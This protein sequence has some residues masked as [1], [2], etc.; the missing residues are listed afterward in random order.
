LVALGRYMSLWLRFPQLRGRLFFVAQGAE[1]RVEHGARIEFGRNVR[2][3]R[4]FTAHFAG[5]VV[6]G[7]SV[8]FNRGC[9]VV[10][11]ERLVI[12]AHCL[13]GEGVSIHDENHRIGRDA[14]PIARRGFSTAP[15]H[16]GRNVWV[17]A[18]VT[19]LQGVSIGDNAV[20]GA[21]A[22]VTHDIP[23]N[24]LALGIPAHVARTI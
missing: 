8:F 17:G 18:R 1:I 10:V 15:I 2:F 14:T 4:D 24:A 11:H 9:H 5:H 7:D 21:G 13:F 19:I 20:I 3:M 23:A 6:I 16:I 12:G 22:V